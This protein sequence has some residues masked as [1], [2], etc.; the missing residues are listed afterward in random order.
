MTPVPRP[1][2]PIDRGVLVDLYVGRGPSLARTGAELGV[3]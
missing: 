1:I 2:V 3:S